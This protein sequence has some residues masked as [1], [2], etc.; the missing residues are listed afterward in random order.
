LWAWLEIFF[1][2]KRYQFLQNTLSPVIFF[3]LNILKRAAKAP[4]V[5]LF[6]L[7]TQRHAKT[8]F[9]TLNR[10]YEHLRYFYVG[11]PR[12]LNHYIERE[13]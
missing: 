11:V 13:I 10:Y 12:G 3:R 2:P 9:L 4:A 8:A 5:D 6:R 7:N 1:S